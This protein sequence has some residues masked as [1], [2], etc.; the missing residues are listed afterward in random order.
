M[1]SEEYSFSRY[2]P[3]RRAESEMRQRSADYNELM[4]KRRS[5]R[6]FSPDPVD[7]EIIRNAIRAAGSAPSGANKQP[8]TFCLVSNP[9]IKSRIR[10]LAEEEEYLSYKK[11]MNDEWLEDL[12]PLGT[13][14]IKPYLEIAPFLIVVFKQ[15]YEM[16]EGERRQ[17]YYVN[18]SVGIAVGMLLSA[19]HYAGLSTLT[20]TPS[21]MNFL[22]DILE[23]PKNEKPYLLIPVGY[24]HDENTVPDISRKA[25]NDVLYEYE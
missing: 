2:S 13:D 20:H 18:E 22:S 15:V 9:E 21:P 25:L 14:H 19:L 11:R 12:R 24:A 17:N 6:K 4:Q 16:E 3:K 5:V 10:E 8:W 7:P 1:S 23:R